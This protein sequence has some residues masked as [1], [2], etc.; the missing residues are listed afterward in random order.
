MSLFKIDSN[1]GETDIFSS[2]SVSLNYSPKSTLVD[3]PIDKIKS[4]YRC[5][6]KY[7]MHKLI[8]L[9]QL[10]EF[11]DLRVYSEQLGS[12]FVND[13]K[14]LCGER[15]RDFKRFLEEAEEL[16]KLKN[17]EHPGYLLFSLSIWWL[18]TT[19]KFSCHCRKA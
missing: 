8:S 15:T 13:C 11:R 19:S 9:N 5:H 16:R 4:R 12:L 14:T 7:L 1:S 6:T 10:S 2:P 3:F 17:T 18:T